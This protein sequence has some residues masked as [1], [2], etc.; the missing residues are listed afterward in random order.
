MKTKVINSVF[1]SLDTG[2]KNHLTLVVLLCVCILFDL[3][4]FPSHHSDSAYSRLLEAIY[5]P[6]NE[7][8]VKV[9]SRDRGVKEAT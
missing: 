3:Y 7:K 9:Y 4:G 6:P 8:E 1:N 5:V 2:I